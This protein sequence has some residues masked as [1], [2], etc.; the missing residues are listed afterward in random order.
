M[1][2]RALPTGAH[3]WLG[4]NHPTRPRAVK[5][6]ISRPGGG[7]P[8]VTAAQI[9]Q[10]PPEI[11][12]RTRRSG[13]F[14]RDQDFDRLARSMKQLIETIESLRLR[15]IGFRTLTEAIDT[16]TPQ[17]VLVFHMFS[18]L[19][20][21]ERALIRERTRAELKAAK[22]MG[23]TGGRPAKLTEDDLDVVARQSRH[24]GGRRCRP[25]RRF[26]R[27]AL[28]VHS[29]REGGERTGRLKAIAAR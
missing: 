8:P 24:S 6:A 20:E 10:T 14:Q 13:L 5:R 28:S 2:K 4:G 11:V 18:A 1:V 29:G 22:R 15:G 3:G 7:W 23:R 26:A 16:A 27:D 9:A 25:D 17:G 21:F 12:I 19:A